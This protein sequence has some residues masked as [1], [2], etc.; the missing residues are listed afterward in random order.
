M[1][2]RMD[3]KE[4]RH[5]GI[6]WQDD[7]EAARGR[8]PG[9]I[10][11][12]TRSLSIHSVRSN[13]GVNP[14]AA[15]PIQYRTVSIDIDD[16]KRKG[17]VAKK[18]KA[19]TDLADLEW[20]TLPAADVLSRLN[21]SQTAGLSVD[22]VKR[23][24][25]EYGRNTPSP[26]ETQL[27]WRVLGYFFKGF[28]SV[29]LVGSILVFIAWKPLG[30][31]PA[32]ANLA[33]AI[34]LLAVFFI[35]AAFNMWQDWSSSR[36][37]ASI[38]NMIPDECLVI[39]EGGQLI[40]IGA[41]DVVPGDITVIKAGDKVPAD[42]RFLVVSSDARFDRSILT[43]ESVPLAAAVDCTDKNYLET[44]NM[45]LQGTHCSSGTCTGIV[46]ATGNHTVFG[47][48]AKLT[49]EP[50]K[51]LTT[52]ER[53]VLN[54]VYVIVSI[55][56]T[57]IVVVIIVWA[58]WL[59]KTYPD[60]IN[61]PTLIVDCVS[62]AVA[63]I[64]EGLPIALTASLTICA[65]MMRKNKVLCKSLKTVET[66]GAVSV[67]CSDKTGTLTENKMVVT[68][69]ALG[70]QTQMSADAARDVLVAER[71]TAGGLAGNAV[72]QLRA[73]AGLC[74]AG[75]FDAATKH[76]PV[77]L[78]RVHGDATDQAILRFAE[79]L[80]S[81]AELKRCWSTKFNLA[82][83]SKNKFMIRVLS[84]AH[85]DGLGV[86]LPDTT[87]AIFEPGDLHVFP[88]LTI[89][90][91]PEILL[92]R[93]TNF[94]GSS[95]VAMT[96]NAAARNK[97][98]QIKNEWSAQGRRVLLLAH[99]VISKTSVKSAPSS[100]AFE[101]EM[102]EQARAGLTIVGLVAIVDPPREEIP[103]VVRTLR[104]AGIRFF[105][106]TG[107]FALTA[108]A[109]A[110][111]C[112]I[113]TN[114]THA[115]ATVASLVRDPED[116]TVDSDR[117]PSEDPPQ[118]TRSMV[119][120]GPDLLT[121]NDAQWDQ[122]VA[123]YTEVV[124]SRTTPEQKLGIVRELQARGHVVGMTGDG[125]NDAPALRAADIGIAV[126]GGSDI[127]IE[128]ADMVL[129]ESFSAVVEAVRYG[130]MVFDNLKKTI[131][132][133]LPAGSFSEFWP[134]LTN[135]V[136]GV[137]QILSSFLMIIIC[138]FTDCMAAT[139]LAYESPEADVLSRPPRRPGV[140]RLVDW[141]LIVQSYGFVG[142]IETVCSFAMSYWYL[143][144]QGI[145]FSV[146]WFS[147]GDLPDSIDPDFYAQK[148]NEASSI[149]FVTLVVMQW[150]NLLAVRTRRL[151]IFQ[152]PPVFNRA[153][154]N[155]Y[156]LPAVLFA[157]VMAFFWL[158]IPALQPTLGTTQV[159]VEH[160]FLPMAFGLGILLLDEARKFAVRKWPKG[161]VA[162]IAW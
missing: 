90:G 49:N 83:N 113:I 29:L 153:T 141:K 11:S 82:F 92:D 122:L 63:F 19:A 101:K 38:K 25:N 46:V 99:K 146:I 139:A 26:P 137:P 69:C 91:A 77:A 30:Q 74:N 105:M 58:A 115:I 40:K 104:G 14:S 148:L 36:V 117:S 64:P 17:D 70:G 42:V 131:A 140:D 98:E 12:H 10:L 100:G 71:N 45:G 138:C 102:L 142:I 155:Y 52:L 5:G 22:Q 44:K 89:K 112:G 108:Q 133:L 127:A 27:A 109:I 37:M 106:V 78:Q 94:T 24:T 79:S 135:V 87:A 20:H 18:A 48:I 126:G 7:V 136:F 60:W 65:N 123:N 158:Y 97:I 75:E 57:M 51:G 53:E 56:A 125:V 120:T 81:V 159:P 86:A 121:L 62:V 76:L 129:L 157:L 68:D 84:M 132:Y 162:R 31:P 43:G 67:I 130:R 88:L 66:L 85:P 147:F 3:E 134:V 154:R 35:Q 41:A 143:E 80:G 149:Y 118:T 110:R 72:D 4:K 152:H 47:R 95:G 55:M 96:L 15:L 9:P 119:L 161:V 124:F 93:C 144:R 103:S 107:D 21:T 2:E 54:F 6:S 145:P 116:K 151:S 156:L 13:S 50:K 28:G 160:W 111:E 39:R 59:R 73:V 34:V 8:G 150:F 33:L 23:R 32:P 128:A 114:P 1:G 16:Y 61:V